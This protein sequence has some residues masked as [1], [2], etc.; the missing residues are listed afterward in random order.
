MDSK[1]ENKV[2][3]YNKV[4]AFF[5]TNL[6]RYKSYPVLA[7]SVAQFN[8]FIDSLLKQDGIATEDSSGY[9]EQK[10]VAREDISMMALGAASGLM[11]LG[12]TTS[13]SLLQNLG[14]I[15]DSELKALKDIDALILS[16]AMKQL[17]NDHAAGLVPYGINAAF[18]TKFNKGVDAYSNALRMAGDSKVAR[19]TAGKAVD[20][21]II[22]ADR[23]LKN[24][25]DPILLLSNEKL[26][27]LYNQYQNIRLID[28]HP[29]SISSPDFKITL[30]PN[31]FKAVTTI[32]YISTRSFK[33]R[34]K[35]RQ[36]IHWGLSTE[37]TSFTNPKQTINGRSITNKLSSTL[38]AEGDILLFENPTANAIDIEVRI[39]D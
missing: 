4:R 22:L 28:D 34:N 26:S 11:A 32:P 37:E 33:V 3:M 21:L 20:N 35:G 8:G 13:D 16:I 9:T 7:G 5:T 1:Q 2:S 27:A 36:P 38:G 15:S 23:Q 6:S 17:L 19:V 18:I 30:E 10:N 24:R 39:S 31:S 25:L 14:D 12:S 29:A